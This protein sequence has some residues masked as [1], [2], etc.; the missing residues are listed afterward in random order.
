M[1]PYQEFCNAR[2]R[3]CQDPAWTC[4]PTRAF[5]GSPSLYDG[6]VILDRALSHLGIRGCRFDYS[7]TA[8]FFP[9]VQTCQRPHC[10]EPAVSECECCQIGPGKQPHLRRFCDD[11]GSR[12]HDTD[13]GDGTATYAVASQCWACGGFDAWEGMS[14][15]EIM[16]WLA[17]A[18]TVVEIGTEEE[19]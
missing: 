1:T 11:H 9:A 19:L 5:D 17:D 12:G 18:V 13:N 4:E 10:T 15:A 6:I 16:E 3:I 8:K 14:D 2:M 7:V